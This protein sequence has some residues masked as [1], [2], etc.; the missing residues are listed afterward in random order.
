MKTQ[1]EGLKN[2]DSVRTLQEALRT[3]GKELR[4][5]MPKK[6]G[7]TP[8]RPDVSENIEK[9]VYVVGI[10]AESTLEE[11]KEFFAPAGTIAFAKFTYKGF[12]MRKASIEFEKEESVK[13][14]I[15]KFNQKTLNEAELTVSE[16]VLKAREDR[17]PRERK[18]RAI[19]AK[20]ASKQPREEKKQEEKPRRERPAKSNEGA[21][22]APE[23]APK[24][25]QGA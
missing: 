6:E 21:R 18:P 3:V 22:R 7:E 17:P 15:E 19:S 13:V 1:I 4:A 5:A 12:K 16:F 14:A 9:K 20:A 2:L 23:K 25:V 11:V 24:E 8:E 10:S